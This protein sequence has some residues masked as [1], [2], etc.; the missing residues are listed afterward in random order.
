[1]KGSQRGNS[2]QELKRRPQRNTA[3]QLA[4]PRTTCPVVIPPTIGWTF[5][6]QTY[7]KKMP[8]RLPVVQSDGGNF[9]FEVL[10]S[11]TTRVCVKLTKKKI[12]PALIP[13]C[14]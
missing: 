10:S 1:M 12:Y 13:I 4:Q 2:R 8:H 3:N 5:S 11:Q 9:S 7:I 6:Q 14:K